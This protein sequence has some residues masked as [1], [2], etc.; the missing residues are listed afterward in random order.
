MYPMLDS[1]MKLWEFIEKI[2]KALMGLFSCIC[3]LFGCSDD[4]AS[5]QFLAELL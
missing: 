3:G 1:V 5:F 4:D 2:G